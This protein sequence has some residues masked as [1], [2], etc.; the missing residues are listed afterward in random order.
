M[1][2]IA[3]CCLIDGGSGP[4]VMSK[5]IMEELGFS[6]TNE[7]TRSMLSYNSLQQTTIGEIKDVTLV[8]C[9]HPEIRTTLNIQVIDMPVSN[10][11]IILGR[12]WKALTGGYLSLDGTHLSVPQNGKNIIVLREGIISPYIESVPQSS[13]NYIE[14]DLGVY[15]IFSEEDNARLERINLYDDMWHMKFDGSCS[16]EGNGVDIILVSPTGRIHNLS[17]SL[18]FSY[19]N[20]ITKFKALLLG[21]EKSLNI[22]CGHLSIFGYSELVVNL[23]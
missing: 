12:Y 11:S 22:G 1:D 21:I 3:H 8:L 20:N 18:E 6:C 5:I 16:N 7:N 9:A 15:S 14:E 4:S 10:Y 17:Y 2:K 19:T 13:V 23:I